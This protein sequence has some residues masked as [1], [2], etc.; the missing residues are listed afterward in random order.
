MKWIALIL[1]TID[2]IASF[3][4]NVIRP[5]IVLVMRLLGRL[6]FPLFCYQAVMS[7]RRTRTLSLYFFRLLL[8]GLLSQLI[9]PLA[10]SPFEH[11]VFGNVIFT[12]CVGIMLLFG[13]DLVRAFFETRKR[14]EGAKE[15]S[16]T[17][18]PGT[19][20]G[21]SSGEQTWSVDYRQ[22]WYVTV[23]SITLPAES[24][25]WFGMV[26]ILLALVLT[27][28]IHPDFSYFGLAGFLLFH[29]LDSVERPFY[30]ISDKTTERRKIFHF[31]FGY[32]VL[33]IAWFWI[34]ILFLDTDLQPALIQLVSPL[35][36]F[37]FPK[38]S[39]AKK[40]N[41]IGKYFFYIY[42]PIHLFLIIRLFL[43]LTPPAR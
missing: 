7:Y 16:P 17:P 24:A 18:L 9:V 26:S 32:V 42:Y 28:V 4:V 39:K 31:T 8:F 11:Y 2:H 30:A 37:L 19:S 3:G 35:A 34:R 36:V 21:T 41:A 6:V 12:F 33:N 13:Y 40:S 25:L 1:M 15:G 14:A 29:I 5:E 10:G 38:L 20:S 27:F 43:D 22:R 23:K